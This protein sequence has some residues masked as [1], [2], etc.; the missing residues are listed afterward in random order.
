[1]AFLAL[2]VLGPASHAQA[3]TNVAAFEVP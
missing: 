2:K 1:M 3:R